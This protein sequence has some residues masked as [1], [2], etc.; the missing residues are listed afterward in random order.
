MAEGGHEKDWDV[1][2]G[3][4]RSGD[5]MWATCVKHTWIKSAGALGGS[6]KIG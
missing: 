4:F 2:F 5:T 3:R 1:Y 6:S